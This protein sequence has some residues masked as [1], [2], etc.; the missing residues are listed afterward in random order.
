MNRTRDCGLNIKPF[1][2]PTNIDINCYVDANFSRL[3]GYKDIHY[4]FYI[5][6]QTGYLNVV[7]GNIFIWVSKLQHGIFYNIDRI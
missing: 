1:D 7:A 3:R 6:S 5:K 4:T 2:R